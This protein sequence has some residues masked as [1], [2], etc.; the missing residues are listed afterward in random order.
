MQT[1]K[2][3]FSELAMKKGTTVRI[4]KDTENDFFAVIVLENDDYF[5]IYATANY[6]SED[7][8]RQQ[9]KL[10][11][12]SFDTDP[13]KKWVI[14]FADAEGNIEINPKDKGVALQ[15]FAAIEHYMKLFYKR[16]RPQVI[17]FSGKETETSRTK[18]YKLLSKKI[19][20]KGYKLFDN[21]M[22]DFLLIRKDMFKL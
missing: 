2:Q 6:Y 21:L 19:E 4:V 9:L 10:P 14:A 5:K 7:Q 20:K 18:L 17:S 16:Q 22:G 15:L 11:N 13:M 8:L 12:I 3:Y 1:F